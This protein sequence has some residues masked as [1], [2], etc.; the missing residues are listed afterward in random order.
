MNDNSNAKF[1]EYRVSVERVTTERAEVIILV[2]RDASTEQM[3]TMAAAVAEWGEP[4]TTIRHSGLSLLTVG[5]YSPTYFYS[6]RAAAN[7][8]DDVK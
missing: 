8:G 4:V 7:A 3:V 1:S 5:D 6:T 2:P